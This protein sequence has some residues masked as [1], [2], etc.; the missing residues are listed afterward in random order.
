[1]LAVLETSVM[2]AKASPGTSI[3]PVEALVLRASMALSKSEVASRRRDGDSG[4][5]VS[6]MI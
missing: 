6:V 2:K 5:T 1:M 3:D 4:D